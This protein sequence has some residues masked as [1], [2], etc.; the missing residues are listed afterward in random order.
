MLRIL[1][2]SDIQTVKDL[3]FDSVLGTRIYCYALCYG[4]DKTFIDFW[5]GNDVIVARFDNTFTV[6]AGDNADFH[7]LREF[8]DVIGAKDIITEEQTAKSLGFT[9]FKTK[10]SYIFVGDGYE[11]SDVVELDES[12]I[13]ELYSV[14]SSSIPD[15]FGS[16]RNAYL[17]FLSDYMFRKNR[18]FSRAYGVIVDNKLASTVITSAESDDSAILSGI[19]CRDEFRKNGLGKKT[20]LT[21]ASLLSK[22]NKNIYVI[23]LNKAAEGFYEHIGFRFFETI[24][25]ISEKV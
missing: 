13:S 12:Y 20:V 16:D 5:A 17:S 10:K 24:S 8:I 1:S 3:T 7:E 23:A 9:G 2:E 21:L 4:F 19:A 22:K 18:G 25:Y 11:S 6:K 14:I 15:S